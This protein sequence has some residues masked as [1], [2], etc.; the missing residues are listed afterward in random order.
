MAH[1]EQIMAY[2][3][4]AQKLQLYNKTLSSIAKEREL[5]ASHKQFLQIRI[6]R[7]RGKNYIQI[8]K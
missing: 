6:F 3:A 8:E 1:V 7:N 2:V 4:N 5:S